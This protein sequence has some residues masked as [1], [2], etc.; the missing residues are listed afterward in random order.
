MA[1]NLRPNR[2]IVTTKYMNYA[3]NI[4]ASEC[5][6]PTDKQRRFLQSMIIDLEKAGFTQ[7]EYYADL[8]VAFRYYNAEKDEY[9]GIIKDRKSY[10][11]AINHLIEFGHEHDM[12]ENY[13]VRPDYDDLVKKNAIS[14]KQQSINNFRN[15]AETM[16]NIY[17][18]K[19]NEKGA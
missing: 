10:S 15:G 19:T 7:K 4:V 16:R 2:K 6:L 3:E 11:Y 18:K 12:F 13:Q 1:S 8:P 9:L 17:L 14:H 5:G